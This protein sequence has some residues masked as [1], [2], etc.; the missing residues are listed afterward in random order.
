MTSAPADTGT[1]TAGGCDPPSHDNPEYICCDGV[2]VDPR[3][4]RLDCGGCGTVC[5][6]ATPFCDQGTCAEVPCESPPCNGDQSCCG[7][8]CCDPGMIC[9][10]INGP[11][12]SGPGC[13]PP[14]ETGSC[15]GGRAP[16]CQCAAPETPVATPTGDRPIAALVPG[17]LVYSIDHG[18]TTVV[19]IARVQRVRV[20][21][22][23]V[24]RVELDDGRRLRVTPS[25]PLADGRAFGDVLVG[26]RLGDGVIVT[27]ETVPYDDDFTHD[28]LPRSS[29]GTYFVAGEPVA[30]TMAGG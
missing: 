27:V 11:V 26:Q 14:T 12:E 18:A 2:W 9:C 25:H 21:D 13:V 8:Q 4:D 29:T 17:D 30:S 5:E 23:R 3:S 15:P 6:G 10:T 20:H 22:H 19:P 1:T 28:I 16:L 7:S 24:A